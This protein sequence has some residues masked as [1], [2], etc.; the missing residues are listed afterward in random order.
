MGLA[1][2]IWLQT[3]PLLWIEDDADGN[4]VVK[5][6]IPP[7]RFCN[8][9]SPTHFP[10]ECA[11]VWDEWEMWRY[12]CY[13]CRQDGADHVSEEC[14]VVRNRPQMRQDLIQGL[15]EWA[16][17]IGAHL[18]GNTCP[19]CLKSLQHNRHTVETCLES[20]SW[21]LTDPEVQ[22]FPWNEVSWKIYEGDIEVTQTWNKLASSLQEC[23]FCQKK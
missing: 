9:S 22:A 4:P 19:L 5:S 23:G 10:L 16:K 8:Q 14:W 3:D 20:H 2:A 7:C 13:K 17:Q 21:M 12:P 11:Q 15:E 6:R 1:E 18:D